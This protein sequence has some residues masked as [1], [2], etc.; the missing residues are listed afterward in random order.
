MPRRSTLPTDALHRPDLGEGTYTFAEASR[1]LGG[2]DAGVS[3][4]Q[5]SYWMK[6][7][8]TPATYVLDDGRPILTFDDLIS[9]EVVRRFRTTG[10]SLQL[11]RHVEQTLREA[12]RFERPFAYKVF[13]TD[14][15][16]VWAEVAGSDGERTVIELTGRRR[17][18]Y[19]WKQ[20]IATFALDIS[21]EGPNDKASKWTVTP[22]V[23]IDP[24]RQF[25]A[26]VVR[27]TRIPVRT[28]GAQLTEARP[29]EVADWYG[30]RVEQVE[31]VRDYL[32]AH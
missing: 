21:F 19:A 26:P 11:I 17:N 13:Y 2:I 18:Q 4:R 32:A 14:G 27:G 23:E 30:L 24:D 20:A 22:W 12:T 9:L 1:I 25:G 15:A 3:G 10:A 31:G 16:T 6:S 8:L 7:G 28:I 29:G 5:L